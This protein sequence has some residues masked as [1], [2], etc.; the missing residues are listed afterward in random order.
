MAKHGNIQ[1][2]GVLLADTWKLVPVDGLNWE[3]CELRETASTSR[4]RES[5]T[6]GVVKWH[7]CGRYYSYN[8][9]GAALLYVADQLTKA[10]CYDESLALVRALD[11][12]RATVDGLAA[13]M[14]AAR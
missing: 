7:R 1:N 14:G 6:N 10:K 3:L 9:I 5:G 2:G 11:Q 12:W 13:R 4:S 8:T